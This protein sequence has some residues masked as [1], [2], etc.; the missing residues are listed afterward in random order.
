MNLNKYWTRKIYSRDP[1][2][3]EDECRGNFELRTN[4][5]GFPKALPHATLGF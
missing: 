5:V 2:D 4:S 3:N 1:L